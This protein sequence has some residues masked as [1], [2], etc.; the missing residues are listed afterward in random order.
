MKRSIC[1]K[2]YFKSQ[3]DRLLGALMRAMAAR[4]GAVVGRDAV[5]ADSSDDVEWSDDEDGSEL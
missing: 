2:L 5:E 1:L 4:T 3:S